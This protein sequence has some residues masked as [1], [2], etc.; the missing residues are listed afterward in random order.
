MIIGISREPAWFRKFWNS[1]GK[2]L[3]DV[4][5]GIAG[6]TLSIPI[7][8]IAGIAILF[9]SPGPVFYCQRRLGKDGRPFQLYKLRTMFDDAEKAT[10][11]V[12]S[13]GKDRRITKAGRF[14]RRWHLD[15]TPQFINVLFG[16]MSVIGPRPEREE[17]IRKIE[18]SVPHYRDRLRIKPGITGLSQVRQ[19]YD[20]CVRDVQRKIRYDLLYVRN[21]CAYLDMKILFLTAKWILQHKEN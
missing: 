1:T 11:P 5:A 21:M 14:L 9:D 7:W 3:L 15:E 2:R 19:G 17:I 20:S 6:I 10:G 18:H 12:W 16:D 13:W 8:T 4:A